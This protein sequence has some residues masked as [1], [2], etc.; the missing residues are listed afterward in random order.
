[1]ERRPIGVASHVER[2]RARSGKARDL[3]APWALG[4]RELDLQILEKVIER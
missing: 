4:I 1:M 2:R 3:G